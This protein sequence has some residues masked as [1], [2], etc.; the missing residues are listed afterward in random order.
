MNIIVIEATSIKQ[1]GVYY[2]KL[3]TIGEILKNLQLHYKMI[4]TEFCQLLYSTVAVMNERR[5]EMR[6]GG[7]QQ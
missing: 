6:N 2:K 5:A 7:Q 1:K 3:R 4:T